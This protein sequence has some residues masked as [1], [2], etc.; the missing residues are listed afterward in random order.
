MLMLLTQKYME[1]A[2]LAA[3]GVAA[4]TA[5]IV[6][7]QRAEEHPQAAKAALYRLPYAI[8]STSRTIAIN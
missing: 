7:K 5:N 1:R 3:E 4:W 8:H 2:H 6:A